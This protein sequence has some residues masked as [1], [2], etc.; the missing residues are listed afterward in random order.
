MPHNSAALKSQSSTTYN[1]SILLV[2]MY[3]KKLQNIMDR[4]VWKFGLVAL[5]LYR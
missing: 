5:I 4:H 3:E 1:T 2:H